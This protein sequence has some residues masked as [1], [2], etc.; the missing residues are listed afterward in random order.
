MRM[1]CSNC[2]CKRIKPC[3]SVGTGINI[4]K[5]FYWWKC[6]ECRC[7]VLSEI[8]TNIQR[9]GVINEKKRREAIKEH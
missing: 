7:I 1:E 9:Y 4:G 8:R 2:G 3:I 6:Q 5:V